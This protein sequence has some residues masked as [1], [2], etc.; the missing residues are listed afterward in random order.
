MRALLDRGH[1]VVAFD[2]GDDRHRVPIAL[3]AEQAA[4]VVHVRGDI[5][6]LAAVERVLDEHAITTV[7]H[8]A[9]LQVP[10]VR[11]DPV[12]GASVNVV[13]TVNVLEA[14]RRR[15]E[16]LP[17]VDAIVDVGHRLKQRRATNG[18]N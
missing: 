12:L 10:F 1:A 13:G 2:V 3:A 14:F 18:S 8:L 11:A 9:A 4:A 6:D 15:E 17:A 7:I 5:T 16:L